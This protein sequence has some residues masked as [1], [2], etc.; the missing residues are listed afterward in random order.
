MTVLIAIDPGKSG[1]VFPN[2]RF[3]HGMYKSR[4]WETWQAMRRRCSDKANPSYGAIGIKVCERW[5]RSFQ[6]FLYDV[7]PRPDGKTLDRIDPSKG[8]DSRNCRWATPTEQARNRRDNVRITA[9]GKTQ[10]LVEW[11]EETGI[12]KATIERRIAR[13]WDQEKAV[14]TPCRRYGE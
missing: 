11:V 13:G 5:E 9:A 14:T 1:G 2:K 10:L 6:D 12:P 4:E 8:Y 7:G 3:K